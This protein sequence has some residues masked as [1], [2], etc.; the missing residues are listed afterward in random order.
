MASI[1]RMYCHWREAWNCHFPNTVVV[2]LHFVYNTWFAIDYL[3]GNGV[4]AEH[5]K[6]YFVSE[7]QPFKIPLKT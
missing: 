5:K 7:T 3:Y 2:Y 4:L 1:W 6:I